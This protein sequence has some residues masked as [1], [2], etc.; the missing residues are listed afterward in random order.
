MRYC[1]IEQLTNG[2]R[3]FVMVK[4][5]TKSNHKRCLQCTSRHEPETS[6]GVYP[7][8]IGFALPR[9][10]IDFLFSVVAGNRVLDLIGQNSMRLP[11]FT[12]HHSLLHLSQEITIRILGL[13]SLRYRRSAAI[14]TVKARGGWY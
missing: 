10:I 5:A 13:A 2:M 9:I 6:V 7:V 8:K 11:V 12:F 14:G 4:D 1:L 3:S